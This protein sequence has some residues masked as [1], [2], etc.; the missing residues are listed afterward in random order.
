M[1]KYVS[2]TGEMKLLAK[3]NEF[4]FDVEIWLLN[5]AVNRNGWQYVDLERHM[6]GFA[7]TPI[8][9]AYTRG[10]KQVGD[11]HNFELTEDENGDLVPTFTGA[12]AE[13][14]V[15]ALSDEMRDFRM[16]ERE[17]NMWIVGTGSLWRWYARELVDKIESDAQQG[18]SM[19]ISIETLVTQSRMDGEVEIEEEYQI[20]GTT[21]LGDHVAPAVRGAKIVALQELEDRFNGLKLRAASYFDKP[22]DNSENKGVKNVPN[23]SKNQLDELQGKFSG[24]GDYTVLCAKQTE[25]GIHIGLMSKDGGTSVCTLGSMDDV[26]TPERVEKVN[27]QVCF[28]FGEDEVRVDACDMTGLFASELSAKCDALST[29]LNELDEC[30]NTIT[31]MRERE[32]TRRLSAAK[33]IAKQT[34]DRFNSN[35]DDKVDDAILDGVNAD[36]E[37]GIY[38]N[39]VDADGAWIGDKAVTDKVLAL[40]AE[41]VMKLDAAAAQ[42]KRRTLSWN[43]EQPTHTDSG[44][45]VADLFHH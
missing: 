6:S 42:N 7:G 24:I 2:C 3:R 25:A 27:A 11:G 16:E 20:L 28:L 36:I 31:A 13:R 17:G 35:R 12:D 14:I 41:A 32:C 37:A 44:S 9:V 21:I 40:C 10:G 33:E 5:D 19:S 4:L 23:F 38:T 34:L 1:S 8:L 45:T 39:S 15:G 30:K 29:A 43:I 18:R 26:V 22:Q